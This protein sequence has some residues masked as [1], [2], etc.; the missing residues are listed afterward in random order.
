MTKFKQSIDRFQIISIEVEAD[1][2]VEA[3]ALITA[4]DLDLWEVT[5]ETLE[6]SAIE[7]LA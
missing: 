3:E 7:E 1:T 4:T 5:Y 2:E 6:P